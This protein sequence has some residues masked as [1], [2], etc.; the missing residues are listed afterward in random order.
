LAANGRNDHVAVFAGTGPVPGPGLGRPSHQCGPGRS[1]LATGPAGVYVRNRQA[2]EQTAHVAEHRR[3]GIV[4]VHDG[5]VLWVDQAAGQ[6]RAIEQLPETLLALA[7]RGLG[8]PALRNVLGHRD[9]MQRRPILRAH[10]RQGEP[11]PDLLAIAA[12][13][14]LLD[15]Q[16]G[17]LARQ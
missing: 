17:G 9:E 7:K 8:S 15:G 4:A 11:G 2:P 6:W 12:E 10:R 1:N 5:R 13:T 3:G 14:P 16:R